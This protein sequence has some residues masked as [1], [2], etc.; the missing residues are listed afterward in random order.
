M[1]Q[2]TYHIQSISMRPRVAKKKKKTS[3]KIHIPGY[4]KSTCVSCSKAQTTQSLFVTPCHHLYCHMCIKRMARL[5]LK[6]RSLIPLRCCKKEFPMEYVQ[7]VISKK[8]YQMYQQFLS[9]RDWRHSDLKTDAEYVQVVKKMGGKQ[10]PQCGIGVIR[11]DGCIHM[12]C[13]SGHDFCFTCL[14]IGRTCTCPT[15]PESEIRAILG[16]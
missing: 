8:D 7:Q 1:R 2:A 15:L 9:E 10:C 5:A 11:F 12:T 3:M 14:A 16:E 4:M 6:D 13:S